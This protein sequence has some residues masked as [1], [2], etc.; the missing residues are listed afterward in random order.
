MIKKHKKVLSILLI[1]FIFFN[2]KSY[3]QLNGTQYVDVKLT[4]PTVERTLINLQSETGFSIYTKEDKLNSI[5][6]IEHT[7]IKAVLNEIEDISLLDTEGNLLFT[8]PKEGNLLLKSNESEDSAIKVEKDRYRDYLSFKVKNGEII[9]INHIEMEHYLYGLVPKEMPYNFPLEALKAQAVAAR[10]YANY[11]MD[12]HKS[13]GFNLCD[14]T[15]C[16]V[17]HGYD[18]ENHSTNL[19]VD[20]TK[21]LLAYYD[22]SPINA[23]YHSTSSGFT[24]DSMNV[25]GGD[26]P[27]LK[28][29]RDEFSQDSPFSSWSVKIDI[30]DLN[31]RLISHGINLGQLEKV[32]VLE[33]SDNGNVNEIKLVGTNGE[34]NIS[35]TQFRNIVGATTLKSTWFN[36]VSGTLETAE[37]QDETVYIMD[38]NSRLVSK[39]FSQLTVLD[40]M[41][42]KSVS[43]SGVS[44]AISKDRIEVLIEK[45]SIQASYT[46]EIIIEGNGYG[47]GVG[48]S[49]YGAKKMAELGYTFEDIL[50]YY[51]RGIDI[52]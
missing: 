30:F 50:K 52:L 27:Y 35:G 5:F 21:G 24:E 47:H 7:E 46:S 49:Q 37:N 9:L 2:S 12:K 33:S 51:Y 15:H 40:G 11:N 17:Y 31:N 13:E 10:T 48:M 42:K 45:E 28:S 44:R 23:Q 39:N 29:V 14:T 41:E 6:Y 43:R 36:I 4:R 22:G 3:G 8:I 38:G 19:A 18:W 25:W 16:Q 32:E 34:K 1:L 20:E 26:L